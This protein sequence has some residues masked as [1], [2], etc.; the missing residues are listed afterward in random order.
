M[1][2]IDLLKGIAESSTR[3]NA[4]PT[5]YDSPCKNCSNRKIGCHGKC[6]KYKHYKQLIKR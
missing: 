1:R 5:K 4:S 2:E 6:E 3:Y